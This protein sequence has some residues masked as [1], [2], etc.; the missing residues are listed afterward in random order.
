VSDLED[1]KEEMAL[2]EEMEDFASEDMSKMLHYSDPYYPLLIAVS[3]V[4]ELGFNQWGD[5]NDGE[6]ED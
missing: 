6:G 5:D 4:R 3:G 2:L 1:E